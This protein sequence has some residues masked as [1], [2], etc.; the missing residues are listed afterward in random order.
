[1]YYAYD[2]NLVSRRIRPIDYANTYLNGDVGA[3]LTTRL[4]FQ[5]YRKDKN[6]FFNL[7]ASHFYDPNEN[8]RFPLD[9]PEDFWKDDFVRLVLTINTENYLV[10]TVE[11]NLPTKEHIHGLKKY[12][13]Y[14]KKS[15]SWHYCTISSKNPHTM[16]FGEWL[17]GSHAVIVDK[18]DNKL[19]D[20][21]RRS[22]DD[23]LYNEKYKYAVDFN[24]MA[25]SLNTYYPGILFLYNL[26]TEKYIE[27]KTDKRDSE[28]LLIDN[29]IVT[30][31]VDDR[32]YQTIIIDG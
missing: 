18:D 25:L 30:Y 21:E 32:L 5:L 9:F 17:S 26:E 13:I 14:K 10:A 19:N 1:M 22:Y 6:M 16:N 3:P 4:F 15:K 2:E 31:R 11:E 20:F 29:N 8:V 12:I 24:E 28:I 27:W 23:R 7:P